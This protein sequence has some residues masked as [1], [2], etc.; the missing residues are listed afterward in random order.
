MM[1][2]GGDMLTSV[3]DLL[4]ASS[5]C[6]VLREEQQ[7]AVTVAAA[8]QVAQ[9]VRDVIEACAVQLVRRRKN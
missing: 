4:T 8:M 3:A 2:G 1:L 9:D 5:E 6:G 7:S